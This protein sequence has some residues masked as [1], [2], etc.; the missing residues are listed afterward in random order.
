VEHEEGVPGS[1]ADSQ[2]TCKVVVLIS[3]G[4]EWRA[5]L[6]LYPQASV[7]YSPY[8]AWFLTT[9]AGELLIFLHGG[10]GKI[11]A[12]GSTQYAIDRWQPDLLVNLGTCG[13]FDGEI[14]R[15]EIILV[16][17]SLVYDIVEQMGDAQQAIDHY[18]PGWGLICLCRCGAD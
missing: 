9:I 6:R 17:R 15:G 1:T 12:A 18:T 16:E 4:A 5:V 11:A 10:W 14:E 8:G 13:G 3:A 2:L 7:Q